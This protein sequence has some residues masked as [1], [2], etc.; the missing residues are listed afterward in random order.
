MSIKE[1]KSIINNV[2]KQ[3]TTKPRHSH[4]EILSKG[5]VKDYAESIGSIE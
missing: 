5:L 1:I 4:W 3:K 2:S